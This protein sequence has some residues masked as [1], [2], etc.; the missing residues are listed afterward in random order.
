MSI[1]EIAFKAE[2]LDFRM[3]ELYSLLLAL[4]EA[5]FRGGFAVAE[6]EMAMT[7]LVRM[8]CELSRDAKET[9]ESLFALMRTDQKGTTP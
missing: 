2:E 1:K 7:L 3:S 8:S 9:T 4:N 5:I 6:Y